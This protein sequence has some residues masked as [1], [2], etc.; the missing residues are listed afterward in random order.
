MSLV[1][2]HAGKFVFGFLG[3]RKTPV[4]V[5][6]GRVQYEYLDSCWLEISEG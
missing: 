2:G 1:V 5:M 4:V 3:E 6:V